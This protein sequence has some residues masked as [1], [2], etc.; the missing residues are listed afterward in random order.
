MNPKE[1]YIKAIDEFNR[2][3]FKRLY[4][5]AEK[6]IWKMPASLGGSVD[7]SL[8]F[9]LANLF[10]DCLGHHECSKDLT[11]YRDYQILS[12]AQYPVSPERIAY[13]FLN[14]YAKPEIIYDLRKVLTEAQSFYD[15]SG[16]AG[17]V[18]YKSVYTYLIGT[19]LS[20]LTQQGVRRADGENRVSFVVGDVG[21]GKTLLLSHFA[22]STWNRNLTIEAGDEQIVPICYSCE[23]AQRDNQYAT[24]TTTSRL[25]LL[26]SVANHVLSKLREFIFEG[27]F[28]GWESVLSVK[29]NLYEELRLVVRFLGR[30]N[31]RILVL[32]DNIDAISY[33]ESRYMFFEDKYRDRITH[34]G[35]SVRNLVEA[36]FNGQKLKDLSLSVCIALRHNVLAEV[37]TMKGAW[38]P[39]VQLNHL[40]VFR[41][42]ETGVDKILAPRLEL[43]SQ[44]MRELT[45]NTQQDEKLVWTELLEFVRETVDPMEQK[46]SATNF[47]RISWLLHQ[48]SRSTVEF[49]TQLS[50]SKSEGRP[51]LSR[52]L[53]QR[54]WQLERLYIA[55]VKKRFTQDANHFPNIFLVDGAIKEKGKNIVVH[56]WSYWLK[57][58]ILQYLKLQGSVQN[59]T[60]GVDELINETKNLGYNVKIVKLAL[61][62]L[63]QAHESKCI[64]CVNCTETA[65]TSVRLTTRGKALIGVSE[66]GNPV[67]FELSYLQMMADD[68]LL[69]VPNSW[70]SK[71]ETSS[72]LEYMF[73][74]DSNYVKK[75]KDE[76]IKKLPAT[77]RLMCLLETGWYHEFTPENQLQQLYKPDFDSIFDRLA[78]AF[79]LVSQRCGLSGS[80][81]DGFDKICADNRHS[82]DLKS[83]FENYRAEFDRL[84]AQFR[85]EALKYAERST[86]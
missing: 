74:S 73:M 84:E 21:C 47:R 36:F 23:D 11:G 72:S 28:P 83:F 39:A 16:D 62:S 10:E 34:V 19:E 70:V 26:E 40:R 60:A 65:V 12:R 32:V 2:I 52:F 18:E 33:A 67:C 64:E 76:A 38:P 6:Y 5:N 53:Y 44:L 8:K 31:I 20:P 14:H 41:L 86:S 25:D 56:R 66:F 46:E 69:S 68:H 57:Y 75:V 63:S 4:T 54:P 45:R 3:H 24:E 50:V 61:G 51:V 82:E 85:S 55:N 7:A 78:E 22:N 1:Q 59:Y 80:D 17:V 48:G 42:R 35:N 13:L 77:V 79:Y 15:D 49:F 27:Q 58:I 30:N 9:Q 71:I 37:Y 81:C 43:F 29:S